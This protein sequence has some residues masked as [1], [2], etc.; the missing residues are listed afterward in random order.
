M[1]PP[2]LKRWPLVH[3]PSTQPRSLLKSVLAHNRCVHNTFLL[4]SFSFA[5]T[6][7]VRY[8]KKKA[9]IKRK[10]GAY[11]FLLHVCV[12]KSWRNVSRKLTSTMKKIIKLYWWKREMWKRIQRDFIT[13]QSRDIS[14]NISLLNDSHM[15]SLPGTVTFLN[16]THKN[17]HPAFKPAEK[18][19]VFLG[20]ETFIH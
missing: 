2:V 19:S 8:L 10:L 4:S 15:T 12:E 13:W 7:L 5:A 14:N 20:R 6:K 3:L 18:C 11:K 1:L 17:G 16:A 9:K